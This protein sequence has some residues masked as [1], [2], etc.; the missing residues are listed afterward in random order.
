MLNENYPSLYLLN[1]ESILA[2]A[3]HL[4]LKTDI[5]TDNQ[6]YKDIEEY[7][8]SKDGIE[9]YSYNGNQ[10]DK[11]VVRVLK[12]CEREQANTYINAVVGNA[13]LS[14]GSICTKWD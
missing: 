7:I 11:K 8:E 1:I 13:V 6:K 9:G 3:R 4:G 10:L 12:I 5:E 14:E 2:I